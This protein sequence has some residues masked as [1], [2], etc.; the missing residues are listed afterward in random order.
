MAAAWTACTKKLPE[1]FWCGG[2]PERSG[3]L[4]FLQGFFEK[5]GCS[6]W[7]FCEQSVVERLV[8][9]VS[10]MQFFG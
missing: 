3:V 8:K 10:K 2:T 5:R 1:F 9:M 6:G 7:I 4:P